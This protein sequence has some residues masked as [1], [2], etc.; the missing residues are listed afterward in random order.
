LLAVNAAAQIPERLN[1]IFWQ[2][3]ISGKQHWQQF[4]RLKMAGDLAAGQVKGIS[5]KLRQQLDAGEPVEI[6]GYTVSPGLARGMEAADLAPVASAE[7]QILWFET[8]LRDEAKF[9]PVSQSQIERWMA[10]GYAVK[11]SVLRGPSFWQTTEI[12]DAPELLAAT[13]AALVSL[14]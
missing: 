8:T 5:A 11:A 12:E 10:A 14:I 2:P 9:S 3:A 13:Q 1:F 6:A 7:G 4:M